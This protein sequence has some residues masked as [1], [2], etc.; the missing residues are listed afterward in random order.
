MIDPFAT[1]GTFAGTVK[2]LKR[3]RKTSQSKAEQRLFFKRDYWVD[4]PLATDLLNC[5]EE[6]YSLDGQVRPEG[7][8]ILG[9]SNNGKTTVALKFMRDKLGDWNPLANT[10]DVPPIIKAETPPGRPSPKALY[11]AL[12]HAAGVPYNPRAVEQ[13]LLNQVC[14]LFSE[15]GVRMVIMDEIHNGLVGSP[16]QQCEM[17]NTLKSLANMLQISVIL[18]GT[19]DARYM[20]QHSHQ[21][22]SRFPEFNM[23][24]WQFTREYS[25]LVDDMFAAT[26]LDCPSPAEDYDFV[27]EIHRLSAGL[28]GLTKR[29]IAEA[30]CAFI[31]GRTHT[32]DKSILS[33]IARPG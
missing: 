21:L 25:E 24:A 27:D 7:M 6:M 10:L 14:N 18:I 3:L 8:F 33:P 32:L 13:A 23:P 31:D 2:R 9:P 11:M 26:G 22:E 30:A 16:N 17:L 4:Y 28:T 19:D 5:L 29:L 1:A 12:L 15:A 20:F